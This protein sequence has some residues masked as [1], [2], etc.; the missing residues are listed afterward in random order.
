MKLLVCS[1]LLLLL[2]GSLAQDAD[3]PKPVDISTEKPSLSEIPKPVEVLT[4]NPIYSEAPILVK[5]TTQKPTY[6]EAPILVTTK[7]PHRINWQPVWDD[8]QIPGDP[9]Q[10]ERNPIFNPLLPFFP[11]R[12]QLNLGPC[13]APNG[14]GIRNLLV[15]A[16]AL[17]PRQR[18]RAIIRGAS[19]DPEMVA[20]VKLLQSP[21]YRKRTASLS[22]SRQY[23]GY[24]DYT[25]YKMNC[26]IRLY[27]DFVK[28][29]VQLN[30]LTEPNK[31]ETDIEAIKG[32]PG[33]R[34]VLQDIRDAL[35]RKVLRELFERLIVRDWYL[36]RAVQRAQSYEFEAIFKML[37]KNEDYK[38]LRKAQAE[39]GMPVEELKKLVY[40]ALGWREDALN[41]ADDLFIDI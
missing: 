23:K 32:R 35:P 5:V 3:I 36:L 38:K 41:S 1:T 14:M 11:I 7:K 28:E 18:I 10:F 24:R 25:C 17:L 34:G 12:P 16:K 39:V 21:E 8:D 13:D 30:L 29:L 26:D 40:Y 31:N 15:Q 20:L 2:G 37:Q 9:R 27:A 4:Q 19:K 33:I 6:S 22:R